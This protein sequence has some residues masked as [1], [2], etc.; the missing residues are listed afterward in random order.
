M[1]VWFTLLVGSILLAVAMAILWWTHGRQGNAGIVDVAWTLGVGL[2]SLA[3]CVTASEGDLA[4]RI[5][6][7][8]IVAIWSGR[9]AWHILHRVRRMPEDG[10]YT[11]IKTAWGA[12]APRKMFFF[13]MFQAIAAVVFSLPMLMAAANRVSFGTTDYVAILVALI[14]LTGEAIADRQLQRFR[15][16]ASNRGKTCRAGLWRYSRHP[17][18]FFEWLHWFVYVL[19]AWSTP[20]GWVT[21]L[22]PLVMLHFVL[23]VTGVPPTE[24]QALRSRGDDYR[25]YQ[26]ETSV[27]FPW[28][29]RLSAPAAT[30]NRSAKVK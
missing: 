15:E 24:S 27:F 12:Q 19:M 23:N 8:V 5:S 1:D 2:L 14:A 7:A 22:A 9:L 28:P 13:F 18:Y 26:R 4:R 17:N 6:L 20:Y 21:L 10:R 16:D 3:Y 29:P 30:V 11:A 25:L